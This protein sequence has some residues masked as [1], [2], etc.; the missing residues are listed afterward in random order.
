[1]GGHMR[2]KRIICLAVVILLVLGVSTVYLCYESKCVKFQDEYIERRTRELLGKKKILKIDME[3]LTAFEIDT[4]FTHIMSLEDLKKFP[5]LSTLEILFTVELRSE[6]ERQDF[7]KLASK[8]EKMHQRE[9]KMLA[10]TLPKLENLKK[11]FLGSGVVCYDLAAFENCN[12]IEELWISNNFV[13]NIDGM[14]GMKKLRILD[15]SNNSVQDI[16]GLKEAENLEGV[17]LTGTPVENLEVLLELPSLKAVCYETEKK[18]QKEI[19]QTLEEKGVIV[20]SDREKFAETMKQAGID[21][22]GD[23]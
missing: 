5:N 4:T 16:S 3:K 23:V 20:D 18:E 17:C 10:D 1:M 11:I 13:E 15:L 21:S 19:L 7:K 12:Q 2:K 9:Q 6:E 14:E 22:I 8:S